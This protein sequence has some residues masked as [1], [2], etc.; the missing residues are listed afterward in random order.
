L[1]ESPSVQALRPFLNRRRFDWDWH[2][3]V[4]RVALRAA[5]PL[6]TPQGHLVTLFSEPDEE[7]L[8]SV[9]L[10]TSSAGYVLEGWG[11][12]PEV[13]HRL[14]W[15]WDAKTADRQSQVAAHDVELLKRAIA[16]E[17]E[18]A[19]VN[20]LCERGEPTNWALLHASVYTALS[21]RGLLSRAAAIPEGGDSPRAFALATEAVRDALK[22]PN[23]PIAHLAGKEGVEEGPWWLVDTGQ[24]AGPAVS[25]AELL[26]VS[27][28]EPP[29]VS[30]AEPP[31]VSQVEPPLADRVGTQVWELLTQRPAWDP[32]ELVEAVYA[33]FLDHLTPDLALVLVCIDSYSTQGEETFRLRPEDDPLRRSAERRT[34]R[35]GLAELGRRLGFEVPR[36]DGWDVRWIAEG[37]EAYV[38]AVSTM[39]ALGRH[40][41]T[42]R[43]AGKEAQRCLVMPGGRAGLVSLKVQ[44][45]PRL[46]R[47]VAADGWQFIKFR[48]LRRLLAEEALDRHALKTVLGLDPIAEQEAAQIPL[49]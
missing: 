32:E 23:A 37:Q 42:T 19:A 21:R 11:H 29:A 46:A 34:V 14:V 40:L 13:G 18:E 6:L 26:T 44:R 36:G 43:P 12:S 5:G 24:V 30:Q 38:F 35:D 47:A 41:L 1:W 33:R 17:A 45:D 15:R 9:C 7:L 3:R 27:E 4:L 48:H 8:E 22:A 16:A 49:F 39:V 20:T 31:V 25:Q 2:W 28:A 10:A